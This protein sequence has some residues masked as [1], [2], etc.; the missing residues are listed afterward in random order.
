MDDLTFWL[1]FLGNDTDWKIALVHS[2]ARLSQDCSRRLYARTLKVNLKIRIQPS[3]TSLF[4]LYVK[5]DCVGKSSTLMFWFCLMVSN[6]SFWYYWS[7]MNLTAKKKAF[8]QR[9]ALS[10]HSYFLHRIQSDC[11]AISHNS[12][13]TFS[14]PFNVITWLFILG[15]STSTIT[16]I[17]VKQWEAKGG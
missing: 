15:C 8:T 10:C 5:I 13:F 16:D 6:L 1:V 17:K 14:K 12:H 4:I 11:S 3:F 2:K 9:K 7:P